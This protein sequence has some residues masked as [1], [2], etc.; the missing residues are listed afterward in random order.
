MPKYSRQWRYVRVARANQKRCA[1]YPVLEALEEAWGELESLYRTITLLG[2][3]SKII[4][5]ERLER[6]AETPLSAL[7]FLT[8]MGFYPPP[9]LLL[10]L[11]RSWRDYL[12]GGGAKSLEEVFLG[13]PRR[14]AG[15]HARR[16][17]AAT[18][19]MFLAQ[20]FWKLTAAGVTQAEAG[21]TIA[22]R[23]KLRMDP[24]SFVRMA[25]RMPPLFK[26]GNRR[27]NNKGTNNPGKLRS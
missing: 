10:G 11:L 5:R 24:E 20:E 18:I 9:E 6:T 7:M 26:Q 16:D 8:E 15:N 14:K 21:E 22:Q 23:Y 2:K 13:R 4:D 12:E 17:R 3:S 1:N 19:R 25:R 27:V